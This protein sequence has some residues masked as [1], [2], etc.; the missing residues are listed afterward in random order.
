MLA[1]KFLTSLAITATLFVGSYAYA[2][3]SSLIWPQTEAAKP[4]EIK[5]F[6]PTL[7]KVTGKAHNSSMYLFGSIHELTEANSTIPKSVLESF[8]KADVAFF[9][10]P[11]DDLDADPAAMFGKLTPFMLLQGN[12]LI[13]NYLSTDEIQQVAKLLPDMPDQAILKFRPWV[14]DM[15]LDLKDGN[16]AGM[17]ADYGVDL[18]LVKRGKTQGK[19]QLG[20]EE[21]EEQIGFLSSDP[22]EVQ[23][24][25]LK[26]NLSDRR[27]KPNEAAEQ[28]AKL[29]QNWVDGDVDA[30]EKDFAEYRKDDPEFYDRLNGQ[31]NRAWMT[32]LTPYLGKSQTVFV[33]VGTMHLIGDDGLVKLMQK[34]GYK[35]ERVKP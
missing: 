26:K 10:L 29:L 8:D 11:E 32:K 33:T 20:L 21:L 23:A 22:I 5:A 4:S 3:D 19:T 2:Q 18:R 25:R 28:T 15:F 27:T 24:K 16:D 13:T 1:Q 30:L 9:E 7:Y 12:D 14:L 34:A 17:T 35:V 31:R 6:T